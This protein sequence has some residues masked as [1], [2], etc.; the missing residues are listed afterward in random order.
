[1]DPCLFLLYIVGCCLELAVG[2]SMLPLECFFIKQISDFDSLAERFDRCFSTSTI[3]CIRNQTKN[4]KY[5]IAML[6]LVVL[7]IP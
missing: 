3:L 7:N 2:E 6:V 1:M 5:S 4:T